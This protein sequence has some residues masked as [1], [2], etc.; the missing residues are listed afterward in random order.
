MNRTDCNPNYSSL[1]R[2]FHQH[3]DMV[4]SIALAA[5]QNPQ[6]AEDI[7]LFTFREAQNMIYERSSTNR[8]ASQLLQIAAA[9][10]LRI[11]SNRDGGIP[12]SGE[13][14]DFF[15]SEEDD[16]MLPVEY[17]ERMELKGR[18]MQAID[19]LNVYQRMALVMYIYNGL[20]IRAMAAAL[21][22]SEDA[23][24]AHLCCAKA[25]VKQQL[26]EIAYQNGEYS[27]N[28]GMVP[29]NRVYC[30]LIAEQA[31]SS[32]ITAFIWDA[33]QNT[34][35]REQY[36]TQ[37]VA[38][39]AKGVSSGSK[40]AVWLSAAATVLVLVAA[41]A[42]IGL[43]P[44]VSS[45][46]ASSKEIETVVVVETQ[47]KAESAPSSSKSSSNSNPPIQ[48]RQPL[49][50]KQPEKK[51]EKNNSSSSSKSSSSKS[52]SKS[53]SSSGSKS[54]SSS[55]SSSSTDDD[56]N[57]ADIL[58]IISGSYDEQKADATDDFTTLTINSD[59]TVSF[60]S[61]NYK[62]D[63]NSSGYLYATASNV[64]KED[65]GIY[66][67]TASNGDYPLSG[68]KFTY[69]SSGTPVSDLPFNSDFFSTS[70]GKLTTPVIIDSKYNVY[71]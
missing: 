41:F 5:V 61:L 12:Y 22:C 32:Q 25:T 3:K 13:P 1:E 35:E 34:V 18:I 23:V 68:T 20:T 2:V 27:N 37:P 46:S 48:P 19:S 66:T 38:A 57:A 15:G 65:E 47:K 43:S 9:E 36:G 26:E 30:G 51:K 49:P 60:Y 59:G 44:D 28:A 6:D 70:G 69:Y 63:D 56:Q 71:R 39:P 62:T 64:V 17:A 24:R 54:S 8:I 55:S 50:E 11:V 45:E 67:F 33:L 21:R 42:I 16:F 4:Y 7:T 58:K 29:F 52:S 31:M 14:Y 40:I 53:S 10:S